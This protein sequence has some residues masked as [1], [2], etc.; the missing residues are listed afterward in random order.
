MI[1]FSLPLL[2]EEHDAF[3]LMIE[4]ICDYAV[5]MLDCSGHVLTWNR[6]AE[7]NKGYTSNE[8]LGRHFK[9][10]FTPEDSLAGAAER[11]LAVEPWDA[12]PGRVGGFIKAVLASGQAVY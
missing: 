5:Y 11:E 7:L 4:S 2:L 1:P 10:F 12:S 6:G 8:I 9:M 3:Q